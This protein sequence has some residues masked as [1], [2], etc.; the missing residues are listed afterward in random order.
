MAEP[1]WNAGLSDCIDIAPQSGL[2]ADKDNAQ[3]QYGGELPSTRKHKSSMGPTDDGYTGQARLECTT[4][5]TK[6]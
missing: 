6:P 1:G 2:K 3:G 4:I 5:T